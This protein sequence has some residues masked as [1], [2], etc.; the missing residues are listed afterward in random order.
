M[1]L[2]PSRGTSSCFTPPRQ[3]QKANSPDEGHIDD[4]AG[5]RT[6][7]PCSQISQD[8]SQPPLG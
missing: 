7:I 5:D 6:G 8:L 4:S 1:K 2:T 3:Q